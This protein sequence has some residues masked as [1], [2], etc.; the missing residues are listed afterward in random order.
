V[1][2]VDHR[3]ERAGSQ[4]QSPALRD[5]VERA[6]EVGLRRVQLLAWRDLD[7]PEA[8]GSELHADHVASMWAGA[9]LDVSMHTS[10]VPGRP[11]ATDRAGYHVVRAGSRLGVFPRTVLR[12]ALGLGPQPDGL[13]EIWNGMP[14][15]SPLWA[16]CPR[17]VFLHHVHAEMW[18][19]VLRP[20][21]A[22]LG[23]FIER[24]L[25]PPL[26]RRSSVVTLSESSRQEIVA[27]LGLRPERVRVVGPGVDP[28]FTPGGQRSPGPLVL[29]VGRLVPV[30]RFDVLMDV[31]T[32][33]R[34]T[35]PD[36]RAVIVGEGYERAR[37][38]AH[39]RALGAE[40][41]IELP[42]RMTDDAVLELYR[43][44][45]VLVSTSQREGWGMTVTEAAACGTPAVVSRIAGHVDAVQDSV[46]GL[47]AG[48]ADG[49]GTGAFVDALRGVLGDPVLRDRLGRGARER[50]QQLTWESTAARTLEALVDEAVARTRR[51]N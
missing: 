38:E 6:L 28:R 43:R 27:L 23:A 18:Q 51:G 15:F 22:R 25:A 12:G 24:R 7:D 29:A 34:R 32:E 1:I 21:H 36:L 49:D 37:L 44:A 45:W 3:H 39:R 5:V 26:Y 9:G 14:F 10:A 48:V 40:E 35:V 8:G 47:V 30:K 13:V 33:V 2:D 4:A 41:W 20:S 19:M 17:I 31:L 42:G 50:A 16:R 46:S 11:R